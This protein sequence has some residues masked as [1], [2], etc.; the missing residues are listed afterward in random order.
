MFRQKW[1]LKEL[2]PDVKAVVNDRQI[3]LRQLIENMG[4]TAQMK[5][6]IVEL[7]MIVSVFHDGYSPVSLV[8]ALD[9][10]DLI[11]TRKIELIRVPPGGMDHGAFFLFEQGLCQEEKCGADRRG[12][13]TQGKSDKEQDNDR[14]LDSIQA[15]R[16]P[17]LTKCEDGDSVQ[18]TVR[19]LG[20]PIRNGAKRL[21]SQTIGISRTRI[22][23]KS[24]AL[25]HSFGAV[26]FD[27]NR[28]KSRIGMWVPMI[29]RL[30]LPSQSNGEKPIRF[31]I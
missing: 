9:L 24:S 30:F 28:S 18:E 8:C 5:H 20:F 25:F 29:I 26:S 12:D 17:P 27:A 2:I 16:L 3:P 13:Q 1:L 10:P 11:A 21:I 4:N 23:T 14:R 22:R 15:H 7:E 31:P 6:G 19:R